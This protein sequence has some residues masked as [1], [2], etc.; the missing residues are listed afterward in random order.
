MKW[1]GWIPCCT[2][3]VLVLAVASG[4]STAAQR[5]VGRSVEERSPRYISSNDEMVNGFQRTLVST[6][7]AA[8][9]VLM[10]SP[11]HPNQKNAT[12]MLLHIFGFRYPVHMVD[13]SGCDSDNIFA[14]LL[15]SNSLQSVNRMG[16]TTKDG[17][18]GKSYQSVYCYALCLALSDQTHHCNCYQTICNNGTI[19]SAFK[20]ISTFF[21]KS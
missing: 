11:G 19:K 18:K 21:K 8:V 17:T 2:R 4:H 16:R 13:G 15:G 20:R 1:H 10:A 5:S 3:I 14:F 6:P 7:I 9:N 12:H